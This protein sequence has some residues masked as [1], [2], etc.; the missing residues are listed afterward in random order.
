MEP[1]HVDVKLHLRK[2]YF[3][4]ISVF[5]SWMFLHLMRVNLSI[6]IVAMTSPR[7]VTIANQTLTLVS[8][9]LYRNY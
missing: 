7:T 5:V 6:S 4:T 9:H 1:S 3:V 8:D 2:R